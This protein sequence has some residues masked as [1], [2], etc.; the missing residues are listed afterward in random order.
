MSM[1]S[2]WQVTNKSLHF[3]TLTL[4]L[5]QAVTL[6]RAVTLTLFST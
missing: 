5:K 4:T 2:Y 1:Y 3:E 6:S